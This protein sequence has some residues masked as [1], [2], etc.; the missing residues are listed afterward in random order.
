MKD[1]N[2]HEIS[3]VAGSGLQAIQDGS[4]T[5]ASFAQ[6]MILRREGKM[7]LMTDLAASKVLMVV[8]MEG[9]Q[10]FLRSLNELWEY[11]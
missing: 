5:S 1:R 6:P 7:L 2:N 4:S 11:I 8:P 3:V 10:G 9:I